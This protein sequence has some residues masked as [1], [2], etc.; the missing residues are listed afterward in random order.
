MTRTEST[1]PDVLK[2]RVLDAD[3]SLWFRPARLIVAG[4]TGRDESAVQDHIE[5]LAQIGIPRPPHVPMYF[6]LDPA[7]LTTDEVVTVDGANTSGEVEPVLLRHEGR[8][9]LGVGSDHTDRDLE[10]EDIA[11][12]KAACPKAIGGTVVSLPDDLVAGGWDAAWDSVAASCTVD[13]AEYQRG[14]LSALRPPSDL[15]TRLEA[16]VGDRADLAVF[17]GTVPVLDGHRT[18]SQWTFAL[19]IRSDHALTHT[20]RLIERSL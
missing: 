1:T 17:C 8:W 7:L 20:Y 3:E 15:L 11:A 2:L 6:D 9:Y 18:G 16:S 13:E 19:N 14:E 5:E 4:Y 10:R 12:S